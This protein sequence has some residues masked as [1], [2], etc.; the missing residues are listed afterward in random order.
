MNHERSRRRSFEL[1]ALAQLEALLEASLRSTQNGHEAVRLMRAAI[2]RLP[3][4]YRLVMTLSYLEGFSPLEIA[5]LASVEQN[6]VET[7]LRRGRR[8]I[9]R[10]SSTPKQSGQDTGAAL[11]ESADTDEGCHRSPDTRLHV[12]GQ[13]ICCRKHHSDSGEGD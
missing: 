3:V 8:L 13:S 10:M 5:N 9:Q 12:C 7:M 4:E 2:V 1:Q 6:V 11:S